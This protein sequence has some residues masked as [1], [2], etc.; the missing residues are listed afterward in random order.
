MTFW[1]F[2]ALISG[3]AERQSLST[4]R[5]SLGGAR[6]S[7]SRDRRVEMVRGSRRIPSP[8]LLLIRRTKK[9][10]KE[11]QEHVSYLTKFKATG[12]S[13][14]K[15]VSNCEFMPH[16]VYRESRVRKFKVSFGR[17]AKDKSIK[18][19]QDSAY[20]LNVQP[21]FASRTN[22]LATRILK[23]FEFYNQNHLRMP[24]NSFMIY[25][26]ASLAVTPSLRLSSNTQFK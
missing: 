2:L 19:N 6:R 8:S 16:K 4:M 1:Q 22:F 20:P 7:R 14:I 12:S 10:K 23:L 26:S 13:A 3:K 9:K 21:H 11:T 24:C 15:K 5:I 18:I 25:C 17:T